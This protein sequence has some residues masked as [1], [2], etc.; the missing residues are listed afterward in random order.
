M[1]TTNVTKGDEK[2]KE[3]APEGH[4]WVTNSVRSRDARYLKNLNY[5]LFTLVSTAYDRDGE[6]LPSEYV[7]VYKKIT[8]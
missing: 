8:E 3:I 6:L 2:R 5:D 7:S 4:Y 1:T